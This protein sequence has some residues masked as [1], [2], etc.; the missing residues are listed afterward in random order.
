MTSASPFSSSCPR[1]LMINLHSFSNAGDAALAQVAIQQ[2][3]TAF[4][5]TCIRLSMNEPESARQEQAVLGSFLHWMHPTDAGG[6]WRIFSI[7][8]LTLSSLWAALTLKLLGK[9]CMWG[10]NRAQKELLQA[11]IEADLVVSAPGNFLYSSGKAGMT[12]LIVIFTMAYASLVGRPLYLMPQ[13]I[14]PL[15]RARDRRLMKWVLERASLVEVREPISM[16]AVIRLVGNAQHCKLVPDLAFTFEGA[17]VTSAQAWLRSHGVDPDRHQPL[18]GVTVID[19]G[20]QS[21]QHSVQRAY[22]Q[23]LIQAAKWFLE[24]TPGKVIFFP[25]VRSTRPAWDDPLPTR[26]VVAGIVD[27]HERVVFIEEQPSAAMLRTACGLMHAFI[28]TRMHSNIFALSGGVPVIAIAYRHKTRGIMQML[29]LENWVIDIQQV[30]GEMLV[31]KLA[32]LLEQRASLRLAILERLPAL[33]REAS[34]AANLIAQDFNQLK[35]N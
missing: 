27:A 29:G 10:L 4:P 32:R 30:S 7:L 6:G 9:A 17:P 18:L 14:G 31:E 12:F 33:A 3:E 13:S 11:Y 25:Q 1:I 24:T 22:E 35:K 5:G 8:Q 21:S 23:A 15:H 19:W 26:R 16:E 28:G 2:L 34:Q 20:S